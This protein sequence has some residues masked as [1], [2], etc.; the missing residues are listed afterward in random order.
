MDKLFLAILSILLLSACG[1]QASDAPTLRVAVSPSAQPV[2]EA[3]ANCAPTAEEINLAIE[4]RYP[5]TASQEDFDLFIQLGGPDSETVFAAQLAWEQIVLVVNRGN[6][7]DIS[8]EAA[9]L[10]FSGRVQNWSDL[11]SEDVTVTL[12][13]GPESDEARQIFEEGVLLGSVSGSARLA[14]NPA[15]A[16]EAVADN[17]GAAAIL[18][19]AWVDETVEQIDLGLQVPLIAVSSGVP[20]GVVREFLACLQ[21]PAG[22]DALSNHYLPFQP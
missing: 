2:T 19:A 4:V 16:V 15:D 3:I 6:D 5:S 22:Q 20:T 7:S 12:W 18:P 10:L 14:T 9:T 13:A 1:S 11:G 17:P 8:R 21:N